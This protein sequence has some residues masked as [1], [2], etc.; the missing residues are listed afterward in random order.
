MTPFL[1][2]IDSLGG[3]LI[4]LGFKGRER[5][6]APFRFEIRVACSDAVDQQAVLGRAARLEI[7]VGRAVR[8]VDGIITACELAT[9]R[10][11]GRVVLR[12]RLEPRLAVLKHRSHWRIFHDR[13]VEEVVAE[14]LGPVGVPF[15]WRVAGIPT[16]KP[17]RCQRGERDLAFLHRMLAEEGVFYWFEHGPQP[18]LVFADRGE[19][20]T[21]MPRPVLRH[22][23]L[24]DANA[25][26]EDSVLGLARNVRL[27]PV[28][29]SVRRFDWMRPA[30]RT[31]RRAGAEGS[32]VQLLALEQH[33]HANEDLSGEPDSADL[34]LH[35]A[36]ENADLAKALCLT[37][38]SAAGHSFQLT[39]HSEPALNADYVMVSVLHEGRSARDGGGSERSYEAHIECAPADTPL[40]IPRSRDGVVRGVETATV[41]G[42]AAEEVHTDEEGRIQLRFHWDT[43]TG[44]HP[45]V[46]A[47]VRVVQPWGG[48]GYGASFT[49]RV[50]NE[51]LVDYIDGDCDRPIVVGSVYNA[52]QKAV[53]RFPHERTRNGFATRSSPDSGSG[54]TLMFEDKRGEELLEIR[55]CRDLTLASDAASVV[56]TGS[57]LEVKVG[58]D[59]RDQVARN[60]S[61]VV[62]G[63]ST[64]AVQKGRSVLVKG[65]D[66]LTV[67]A[68]CERSVAGSVVDTIAGNSLSIIQGSRTSVVGARAG[69]VCDESLTVSGHY[70]VGAALGVRMQS[71]GGIEFLCGKSRL[72]LLPDRILLESPLLQLQAGQAIN[73]VQ[74]EDKVESTLVL[75]GSASLAGGKTTVSSGQGGILV[76]DAE[77]KLNGALVKLNCGPADAAGAARVVDK[78]KSGKA[79]FKVLPD[80]LPPGTAMV[81]LI[82][83]SPAGE[84]LERE[85]A[86]NGTVSFDGHPGERFTLVEMRVAGT[87]LAHIQCLR[88]EEPSH[89]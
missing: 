54:H 89:G 75:D 65:A 58:G 33:D 11:D 77:A 9:R 41:M 83:Q 43:R 23:G 74:G 49:P 8:S 1:L 82:V 38:Q 71:P 39:D 20:Y 19:A 6:N 86:V 26:D 55:S 84:L 59:R 69:L 35:E 47:W 88:S 64:L 12:L 51:V 37:P 16:R 3:D 40:L 28:Q 66:R 60:H 76:L 53:Q 50:G 7:T 44:A 80:G 24:E 4:V 67:A 46:T 32:Q 48:N 25:A 29:Q 81:T 78:S 2:T 57:Q 52:L 68:N 17:H 73:L 70:H 36:R 42:P 15:E 45:A 56:S 27:R 79:S 87:R 30:H 22:V 62:G 18:M 63:H 61:S 72:V 5:V 13:T 21:A 31:E 14:L 10:A 34:R 85:C